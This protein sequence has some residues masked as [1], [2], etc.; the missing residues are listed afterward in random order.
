MIFAVVV[1]IS[2]VVLTLAIDV[3]FDV[4]QAGLSNNIS[5]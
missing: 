1:I 3:S 5:L 4:H 2:L